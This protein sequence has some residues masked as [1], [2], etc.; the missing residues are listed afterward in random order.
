MA[1]TPSPLDYA[2]FTQTFP[3]FLVEATYPQERVQFWIDFA[4]AQ[5]TQNKWGVLAGYGAALL[6]AHSLVLE[7]QEA[8]DSNAGKIVGS[9]QGV[10]NAASVGGV[11]SSWDTNAI[12][13]ENAGFFNQTSYGRRYWN[14][15]LMFGAG[16]VQFDAGPSI[17]SAAYIGGWGY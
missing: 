13:Y 9:T 15:V 1:L 16:P 3:V 7:E 17:P 5:I 8:V 12:T 10:L 2:G 6:T 11:S 4:N 14:Y